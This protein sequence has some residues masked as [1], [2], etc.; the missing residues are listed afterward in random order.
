MIEGEIADATL[1]ARLADRDEHAFEMLFHRHG[2]AVKAVAMRVLRSEPLAEDVVQDTFTG[3]WTAPERFRPDR[4]SLQ[5][6]LTTV[7]HRRAVDIVRSEVARSRRELRPPEPDYS[8]VEEEVV[9]RTVSDDVRRALDQLPEGE[10]EALA[11]AY[12]EGLSYTE[13]ARRLGQPEG[14]VKSRIRTGMRRLSASLA[15]SRG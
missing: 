8:S 2:G 1:T 10:R 9:Q 7:A 15:Q 5:S 3:L 14:T 12:L 4:G 6:F 11:L 13:V